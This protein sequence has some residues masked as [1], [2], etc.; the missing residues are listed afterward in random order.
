MAQEET[1]PTAKNNERFQQYLRQWEISIPPIEENRRVANHSEIEFGKLGIQSMYLLN[2]GAAVGVPAFINKLATNDIAIKS[3]VIASV[4]M[5]CLGITMAAA[6]NLCAFFASSNNVKSWARYRDSTS[7]SIY[8]VNYGYDN[9]HTKEQMDQYQNEGLKYG[10]YASRW[11]ATAVLCALGSLIF[12][13][14]GA[15]HITKLFP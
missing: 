6:A 14:F 4:S 2:G 12:F 7:L 5:F 9:E 13:A 15:T 8:M 11:Q 3:V 10:K 1:D